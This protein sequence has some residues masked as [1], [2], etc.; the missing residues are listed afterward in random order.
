MKIFL[1]LPL[2]LFVLIAYNVVA[3]T[4]PQLIESAALADGS[5]SEPKRLLE[6][7]L[8]SG[9]N[10]TLHFNDLILLIGVVILYFELFKSTRTQVSSIVE[11]VLSM[12]VFIVFL[13]EF[14]IVRGC[15]N[16][17]F[18][19]LTLLSMLDV[20]AGFTITISTARRDL[21]VP[22]GHH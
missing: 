12:F 1:Q 19:T 18:L 10:W 20:V 9:A 13:V 22:H 14:I 6:M 2:F 11:H 15:G 8:I 17:T 16:S 3:F 5:M 21:A 7:T 4:A